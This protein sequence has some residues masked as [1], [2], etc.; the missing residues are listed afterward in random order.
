MTIQVVYKNKAK[1]GNQDVIAVFANEKFQVNNLKK[2]QK[3]IDEFKPSFVFHLAAQPL[4]R[5]SYEKPIDT[6]QTNIMGTANL[7][8]SIRHASSVKSCVILTSDKCYKNNYP[9]KRGRY[10]DPA[11]CGESLEADY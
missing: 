2:L 6:L 11:Y 10:H 3:S 9:Y 8:E 7:L 4:V 5:V 1:S